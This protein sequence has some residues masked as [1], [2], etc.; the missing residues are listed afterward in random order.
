MNL[1]P[2]QVNIY[3]NQYEIP[4]V[5][6]RYMNIFQELGEEGVVRSIPKISRAAALTLVMYYIFV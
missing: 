4:L 2:R 1:R 5:G 6:R 3:R